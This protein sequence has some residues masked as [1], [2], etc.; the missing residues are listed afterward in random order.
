MVKLVKAFL[1][2]YI[3]LKYFWFGNREEKFLILVTLAV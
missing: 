2:E 1:V 3:L